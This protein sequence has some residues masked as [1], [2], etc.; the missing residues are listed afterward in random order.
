MMVEHEMSR[1]TVRSARQAWA[2]VIAVAAL[3]TTPLSSI[4]RWYR[5]DD[6]RLIK[7]DFNDGDSFHVQ[8]GRRHYIFRLYFVDAPETDLSFPDRVNAQAEY[9][10][11][12]PGQ[13]VKL[14]QAAA[15]FTRTFLSKPFTVHTKRIDA[16]GRS[17]RPRYFGMIETEAGFLSEALVRNG[18]ARVYGMSTELP[19]GKPSSRHWGRLRSAERTA[20]R[21]K[22]GGWAKHPDEPEP[23]P[24]VEP[25]DYVVRT[26]LPVFDPERHARLIGVLQRGARIRILGAENANLLRIRFK[27]G[28]TR[29]EGLCRRDSITLPTPVEET[30]AP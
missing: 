13:T 15:R 3:F 9:W 1:A 30:T 20:K 27:A 24:R 29:R 5:Y 18:L 4:A 2:L 22:L 14:G 6:S 12:T 19:D 21:E 8:C 7:Q 10:A 26:R 16:R 25:Q 11:L 28:N 23:P 17:D